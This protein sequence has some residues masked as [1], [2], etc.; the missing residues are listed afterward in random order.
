VI[1]LASAAVA[2]AASLLVLAATAAADHRLVEQGRRHYENARLERALDSFERA[3]Q[4]DGLTRADLVSLLR[5]RALVH[6]AMGNTNEMEVDLFKLATL[7]PG[8]ELGR[9]V[10][11]RVRDAFQAIRDRGVERLALQVDVAPTD[12]G[13]HIAARVVHDEAALTRSVSLY[14]RMTGTDWEAAERAEVDVPAGDEAVEYYAEALGPGGAVLVSEGFAADPR[15]TSRADLQ[16]ALRT[17]TRVRTMR[18]AAGGASET[19]DDEGGGGAG[20]WIAGGVVLVAAAVAVVVLLSAG[21]EV[22]TSVMPPTA[23]LP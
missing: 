13:I 5:T 22:D 17:E 9:D 6:F 4:S 16:E 21:G 1:R 7:E 2:A 11:P 18:M 19:D 23:D 8:L 3:E 12:A 15:R 20:W 10:P 14:T